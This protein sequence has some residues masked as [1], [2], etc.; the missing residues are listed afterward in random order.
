MTLLDLIDNMRDNLIALP[1]ESLRSPRLNTPSADNTTIC[2][3]LDHRLA[4][5][6]FEECRDFCSAVSDA[7][8]NVISTDL[9]FGAQPRSDDQERIDRD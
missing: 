6:G 1:Q 8:R 2:H 7:T 9:N 3:G 4:K 5:T